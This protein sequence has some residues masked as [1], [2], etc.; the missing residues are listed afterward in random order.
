MGQDED[1]D[2]PQIGLGPDMNQLP[3]NRNVTFV[4]DYTQG[5]YLEMNLTI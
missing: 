2:E 3:M 5:V 1:V 4:F